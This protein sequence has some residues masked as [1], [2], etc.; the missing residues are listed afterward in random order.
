MKGTVIS[1]VDSVLG[2]IHKRFV[3]RLDDLEIRKQVKTVHTS[4][5]LES[6][7]VL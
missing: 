7:R 1:V 5:S 6:V 3:K 2:P 4:V